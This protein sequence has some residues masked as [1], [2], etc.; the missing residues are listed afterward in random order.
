MRACQNCKWGDRAT[1]ATGAAFYWCRLIPPQPV[2]MS[3]RDGQEVNHVV[4][5]MKA[6]GWC[7]QFKL[8]FFRWLGNFGRRGT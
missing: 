5:P 4:P 6:N 2:V 7:G 1:D 8:A 3:G